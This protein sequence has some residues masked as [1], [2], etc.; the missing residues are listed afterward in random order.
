MDGATARA[1][2]TDRESGM[3]GMEELMAKMMA[4]LAMMGGGDDERD[5]VHG[6]RDDLDIEP[7]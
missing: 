5:D 6:G 3:G 7:R 1:V 2:M 4:V